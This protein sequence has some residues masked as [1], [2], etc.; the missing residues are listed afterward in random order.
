MELSYT[1]TATH[2]L[3]HQFYL[4]YHDKKL[5]Q[6]CIKLLVSSSAFVILG[7]LL[8]NRVNTVSFILIALALIAIVY[9]LPKI[10]WNA[11]YRNIERVILS[12]NP[13]FSKIRLRLQDHLLIEN[14]SKLTRV[15]K[16]KIHDVFFTKNTCIL[17]YINGQGAIDSLLVPLDVLGDQVGDFI[18]FVR[19][20]ENLEQETSHYR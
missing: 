19:K 4:A 2:V 20:G 1:L 11:V 6:R 15:E 16:D 18:D 10:Y 7:I 3:E 13:R 8:L 14:Q 12:K 5:H 9:F 17:L